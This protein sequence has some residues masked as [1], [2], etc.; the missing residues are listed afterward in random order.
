MKYKLLFV[1]MNICS[2]FT[3][4]IQGQNQIHSILFDIV[5]DNKFNRSVVIN[6]VSD[7]LFLKGVPS[8]H[9]FYKVCSIIIDETQNNNISNNLY[10]YVGVD[11]KRTEKYIIVDI[12]NNH[13]L[14]DDPIYTFSLENMATDKEHKESLFFKID[15]NL[16]DI[17]T[18]SQ[19][20]TVHVSIDPFNVYKIQRGNIT[21]SEKEKL[22]DVMFFVQESAVSSFVFEDQ[23]LYFRLSNARIG[24]IETKNINKK[25]S[26]HI[27]EKKGDSILNMETKVIGDTINAIGRKIYIKEA[28]NDT[29]K[30]KD[31]GVYIDS[32][33]VGSYIPHDLFSKDLI[34]NQ[35]IY[36]NKVIE[37][38]YVLIDFWG[39]WCGPC[40][41]S[42][43]YLIELFQKIKNRD[44]VLLLGIALETEEDIENLK[45][46]I[47]DNEVEWLNVWGSHS[48]LKQQNSIF[49]KLKILQFPT[50]VILDN[51][52]KIV[53]KE[54]SMYKTDEAVDFF[55][56][57]I[58]E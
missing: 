29:L 37:N 57:L 41:E 16:F 18:L 56:K 9:T 28:I 48:E 34:N 12:N 47:Y 36:L 6:E 42:L 1:L 11:T 15:I 23:I 58:N 30:L 43:P 21:L 19:G 39:S 54:H 31:L 45:K 7:Y 22:L 53:Y 32:S 2:F 3:M 17:I 5:N 55:M 13:D 51:K 50:Y 20:Y 14:S 25:T 10:I 24:L 46:I 26:F 40:I 38:K 35:N 27:F 49:S 8:S 44:D 4:S 33:S 52:G